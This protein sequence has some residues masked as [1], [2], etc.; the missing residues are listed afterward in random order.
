MAW[1]ERVPYYIVW[2]P[3][4]FHV[5]SQTARIKVKKAIENKTYVLMVST[6]FV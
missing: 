6:N 5:I 1:K 4:F 2:L 3:F